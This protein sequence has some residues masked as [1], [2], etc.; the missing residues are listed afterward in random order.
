MQDKI[1]EWPRNEAIIVKFLIVLKWLQLYRCGF[2]SVHY[3]EASLYLKNFHCPESRS[4]RLSELGYF[5]NSTIVISICNTAFL[6]NTVKEEGLTNEGRQHLLLL[7]KQV[8]MIREA[9][10][11][12]GMCTH[13]R[14]DCLHVRREYFWRRYYKSCAH[15]P[16]QGA[17]HLKLLAN[18]YIFSTYLDKKEVQLRS[19]ASPMHFYLLF[20][21]IVIYEI[22][23]LVIN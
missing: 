11:N 18:G 20:A 1:W 4:V 23:R 13:T 22:G 12:Y 6:S 19:Q 3:L 17:M 14:L 21:F 10:Q 9:L 15:Y 16:N 8:L 5:C 7:H 2:L